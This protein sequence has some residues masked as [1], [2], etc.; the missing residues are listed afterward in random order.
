[1]RKGRVISL[2]ECHDLAPAGLTIARACGTN[3][4]QPCP[5][6]S[7]INILLNAKGFNVREPK[8]PK[9]ATERHGKEEICLEHEPALNR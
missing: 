5:M 1:M 7:V 8:S 6:P 2:P 9:P 4:C 3:D